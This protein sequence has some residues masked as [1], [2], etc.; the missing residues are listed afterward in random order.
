MPTYTVYT[1]ENFRLA[2]FGKCKIE[3]ICRISATST[4][5][6]MPEI[7]LN[8]SNEEVTNYCSPKFRTL[9]K[10]QCRPKAQKQRRNIV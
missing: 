9:I 2:K 6:G 7:K 10:F 4:N 1:A 8:L 5:K 3:K